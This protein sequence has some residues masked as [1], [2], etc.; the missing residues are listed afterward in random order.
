MSDFSISTSRQEDRLAMESNDTNIVSIEGLLNYENVIAE[1]MKQ[2]NNNSLNI[3]TLV[4]LHSKRHYFCHMTPDRTKVLLESDFI[5]SLFCY[6][7]EY[8]QIQLLIDIITSLLYEKSPYFQ[9]LY[10]NGLINLFLPKISW[11]RYFT[12]E[13]IIRASQ[14]SSIDISN[15]MTLKNSKIISIFQLLNKISYNFPSFLGEILEADAE[16][17]EILLILSHQV[18]TIPNPYP[19]NDVLRY[20]TA[21]ECYY[22]LLQHN[23]DFINR[24]Y[25][26]LYKMIEN[27]FSDEIRGVRSTS[28]LAM[29]LLKLFC[30]KAIAVQNL[31]IR[32]KEMNFILSILV[33]GTEQE[34]KECLSLLIEMA[35]WRYFDELLLRIDFVQNSF[36]FCR[37]NENYAPQIWQIISNMMDELLDEILVIDGFIDNLVDA[38]TNRSIIESMSASLCVCNILANKDLDFI[39]KFVPDDVVVTMLDFISENSMNFIKKMLLSFNEVIAKERNSNQNRFIN[40]LSDAD[41]FE[42][43]ENYCTAEDEEIQQI[44]SSITKLLNEA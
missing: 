30:Q 38:V 9:L 40:F 39:T 29:S 42:Q 19:E 43:I 26:P 32:V 13:I 31:G 20:T 14:H 23:N 33:N 17:N 6:P 28:T 41:V 37:E 27:S 4:E 21:V 8:E 12:M 16:R 18:V 3:E 22:N 10:N 36:V 34:K 35:T 44:A 24:Y 2:T 25:K 11:I 1:F 7:K 5:T 15:A